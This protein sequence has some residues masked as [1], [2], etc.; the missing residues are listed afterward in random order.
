MSE[1][2]KAIKF[3]KAL[4]QCDNSEHCHE[5]RERVKRAE[6]DE[7][8]IRSALF[9]VAVLGLL[10]LSGIGYSAVLV[11]EFARFSSHISTKIF[12][13]LGL[14]SLICIGVFLGVWLHHRAATNRVYD[15]CRRFIH[16]FMESR[17]E[18]AHP[19]PMATTLETGTSRVYKT[20]TPQPQDGAELLQKAS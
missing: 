3:L 11:H 2:Q 13:A 12:C 18:V 14:A 7:K 6:R 17:F 9:L 19:S 16:A 5:L 1:R 20:K 10:S 15:E 4:I 8:C